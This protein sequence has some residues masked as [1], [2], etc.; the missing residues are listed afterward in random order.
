MEPTGK[1][2]TV[3][4]LIAAANRIILGKETQIRRALACLL[5]RGHL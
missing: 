4:E 3:T 1:A 2:A 5:A